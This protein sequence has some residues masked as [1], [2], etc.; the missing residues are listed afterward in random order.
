MEGGIKM[1][2][3]PEV[4]ITPAPKPFGKPALTM[5][6]I[7]IEPIAT[8]VAGLEPDTAANKAQAS[9]PP[10][11]K[12]PYQWPTMAVA[13]PI[14]RLATPPWVKKLPAKMKNGIAMISNFSIPVNNFK[15]TDSIGTSVRKN[16]KDST[17][18]PSEMEIGMPV[19]MSTTK[20]PKIIMAFIW[21]L[22]YGQCR[23]GAGCRPSHRLRLLR[24][25]QAV[26]LRLSHR[27]GRGRGGVVH[28]CAKSPR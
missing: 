9:T 18:K 24:P 7:K 27:H 5:A 22:L 26:L 2:K 19:S 20:R 23:G 1:P 16:K 3:A 15:A 11:P 17:V 6:G 10:K 13:K 21:W 28:L 14:M 4:V 12:P 8:T 25:V